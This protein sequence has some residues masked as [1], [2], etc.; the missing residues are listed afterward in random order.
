[1][2]KF[3]VL[4]LIL[5]VAAAAFAQDSDEWY[6]GKPIKNIVFEGLKNVR[7]TELEGITDPFIG[8]PFSDDTYWEI[9]G[10]LYALE[11][12]DTINPTAMRA[13]ALG[14]EV[15]IRFQ[16]TERPIVSRINFI[17]NNALRRNELLD[18]VAIKI[19]DVATQVKLR[20]DETA[21]VNKYLEKGYPDVKVRSEMQPDSANTIAVNF[22]IDEG[23]KITIDEF[24][25]EGN[26]I[27]SS[28][29]LEKQLSMKTKSIFNDGA[30]QESKLTADRDTLVSYY[31]DRGYIDAAIVD[32]VREI[33]KDDKGNNSMA[34]TFKI[35]EGRLY[36]FGG[37][38]FEGN[39]IFSTEQLSAQVYS[40]PGETANDRRIQAD[41]ARVQD[42]Y[43]ESGYIFNYID[44]QMIRNPENGTISYNVVIVERG[45]AHIENIIIRGNDKTKESVILQEL[46]LEP[47]DIFSKTKVMD[48]M[49]N[50]MNLQFFS[51]VVPEPVQGSVDNLMDLVINVEEQPTIDLNFGLAFSGTA[52]PSAFP[53]SAQIKWNDRNFRGS[54]NAIGAE[55]IASPDTQ[56]LALNYTQRRIIPTLPLSGNFDLT[57]QHSMSYA[58]MNNTYPFFYNDDRDKDIAYPD[59][60][61]SYDDYIKAG[62]VPPDEYMMPYDQWQISLGVGSGYRWLTAPGVLTLS[63]GLRIGMVRNVY[64]SDLY[65][66]FDP[67]L[68]NQNNIWSPATSLTASISLDQRDI[69]YDPSKGYFGSQRIGYYGVLD[70]EEE[71]Y[72]RTDT[73]AEWFATLWDLRVSDTWNFKGVFGIHS[74]LSFILPQPG[75]SSPRIED[76][77]RLA[78]DG[79]F[80]GRGWDSEYSWKGNALWENWAELRI[81]LV[82]NVIS[83]DFFFDAAGVK[84]NPADFFYNFAGDDGR[85]KGSNT[86]FLRFSL[87]GG[88]R[89]ALPQFPIRFSIAKAFKIV[90][91]NIQWQSGPIGYDSNRPDSGWRFVFSFAMPTY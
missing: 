13:D 17:G 85:T 6:Q 42:L 35:Y 63:G 9:L 91:G 12:F 14:N 70:F 19:H 65:R 53:V 28:R 45:R 90:D 38:T 15:I 21:I 22:Y 49:R 10:R 36:T 61:N 24:R 56:S 57:V 1:M 75:W 8:Q 74:G 23:D 58:A 87:G 82:P 83:W 44:P 52:D 86:F 80:V 76:A 20:L 31:H 67:V 55:L 5:A 81:P 54:G 62:K 84:N 26:E 59:G 77:N 3:F 88:I 51:N 25:F 7:L 40:K 41:L 73:K 78:V 50:L 16:V 32:V 89:F 27:F 46:P 69:Y 37:V 34:I 2:R 68:R 47:G 11:Y 48:G 60:F 29:T 64:N 71:H 4:F 43:F 30:F 72:I 66:P 33:K 79:M 18:L 39:Q